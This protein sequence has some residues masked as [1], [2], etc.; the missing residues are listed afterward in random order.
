MTIA[1]Y[2][3]YFSALFRHFIA[4]ISIGSEII[5]KL[6]KVLIGSVANSSD[7]SFKRFFLK[8]YHTC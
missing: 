3:A 1:K 7:D 5:Q 8:Y 4:S 6:T 2:A